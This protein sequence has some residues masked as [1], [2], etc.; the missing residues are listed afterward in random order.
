MVTGKTHSLSYFVGWR[1]R[2]DLARFLRERQ[3]V[4]FAEIYL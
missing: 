1:G 4:I 3:P 2:K